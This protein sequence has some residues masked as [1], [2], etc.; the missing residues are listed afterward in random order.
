MTAGAREKEEI[1]FYWYVLM[2]KATWRE[3]KNCLWRLV[4]KLFRRFYG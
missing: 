3:V 1:L 4:F 2:R